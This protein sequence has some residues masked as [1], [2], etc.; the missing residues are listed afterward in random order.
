MDDD[1]M[2]DHTEDP[3]E[4]EAG[5]GGYPETNPAGT[6]PG[7]AA[8]GPGS[9]GGGDTESGAPSPATDEETDRERSTGNPGAAG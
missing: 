2:P 8:P 4:Q 7:D 9:A 1:R 6:M 3:R 5:R